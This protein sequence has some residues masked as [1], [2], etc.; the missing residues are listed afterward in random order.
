MT[1]PNPY[2]EFL[3]SARDQF[4]AYKKL[5]EGAIAQIDDPALFRC[6][7]P[8]SNSIAIVIQHL[9]GNMRSRWT[10][11]LTTDGEKPW[12][13]RDAEFEEQVGLSRTRL[14]EL[15]EEGWATLFGSM[16]GLTAAD[17]G[18]TVRI[19][20]ESQSVIRA[21]HRQLTHVA[22]HVGQIVHMAKA[23]V[24]EGRWTSLSIP[25]RQ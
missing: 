9:H 2:E 5:G 3:L 16:E 17:L 24:A 12:R 10:D 1:L 13:R 23:E 22:Y 20:G 7:G 4:R 6:A 25:R 8:E 11:F 15:W 14:L 19:R 21:V 18:R